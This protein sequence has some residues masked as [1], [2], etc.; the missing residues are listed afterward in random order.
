MYKNQ[1]FKVLGALLV[2]LFVSPGLYAQEKWDLQRCID[3]AVEQNLQLKIAKIQQDINEANLLQ[4]KVNRLPNLNAGAAQQWN[5]GRSID[6]FTNQFTNDRV[7]NFN[8][9][10]S[11]NLLLFNGFRQVNTIKQNGAILGASAQDVEQ[12]KND[13]MINIATAYLTILLNRELLDVAR[14]QLRNTQEQLDRTL[15]LIEAG[16]LAEANKYDILSQKANDENRITQAENSVDIAMARLKILL[17]IPVETPIEVVVPPLADPNPADV[18]LSPLNTYELAQ[19]TQ[20]NVISADKNVEVARYGIDIAKGNAYPTLSFFAGLTSGTSSQFRRS[21]PGDPVA[22]TIGFLTGNPAQSVTALFPTSTPGEVVSFGDQF[23]Q[24]LRNNFGFQVQIPIFNRYQVRNAVANA[25]FQHDRAKLQ[26]LNVRNTLRQTIEQAYA[27][28]KA[29]Q[30]SFISNQTRAAALTE[31]QKV[32]EER[33][34]VGA[35]NSLDYALAKNNLAIAQ[36]DLIRSK[37][38]YI[39]RMKILDFY[40]GKGL[41]L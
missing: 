22:R 34:N 25:R 11:A 10:L 8:A 9:Q 1:L 35:A 40:A 15:R 13:M 3:H 19:G 5:Q 28:A 21:I 31:S 20:P 14:I 39:F 37:Y 30:R 29:A 18:I 33:F 17:Q 38:D 41:K 26:A 27:D 2:A 24:N 4:S 16:S 32:V 36:S 6:Q 23:D 12:V 7:S